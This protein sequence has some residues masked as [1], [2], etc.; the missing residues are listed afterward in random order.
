[1]T[2]PPAS[3]RRQIELTALA[4]RGTIRDVVSQI[5]SAI[6][7]GDLRLGDRLPVERTLAEQLGVSRMT[8]RKGLTRLREAGVLEARSGQGRNSGTFVKSEAVPLELLDSPGGVELDEIADALHAR[9]LLEPQVARLAGESAKAEDLQAL[10]QVL[11]EQVRAGND[12]QRVRELDP[13]F[14]I[15]IARATHNEVVVALVQTLLERLELTR[16]PP[17]EDPEEAQRTIDMHQETI[18]AIASRDPQ[19]IETTMRRHL[20]MLEG[21][22]EAFTGRA[23]PPWPTSAGDA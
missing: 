10:R 17:A 11:Y 1:M 20:G 19:R 9:R 6:Q 2:T 16:N 22:W 8:V 15:G 21:T 4:G 5:G 18:D 13:S 12:T 7:R 3:D 23:M 14:H